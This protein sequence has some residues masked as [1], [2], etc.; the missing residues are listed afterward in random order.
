MKKL[1]ED[2]RAR[3]EAATEGPWSID[4]CIYE[5]VHVSKGANKI[6][7]DGKFIAASRTDIPKLL[8]ALDIMQELINRFDLTSDEGQLRNEA[9]A[10]HLA[11]KDKNK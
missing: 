4:M 5:A 2:I 9:L 7:E 8:E 6:I 10:S 3:V 1:F 11:W